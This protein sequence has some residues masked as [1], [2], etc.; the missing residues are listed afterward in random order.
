MFSLLPAAHFRASPNLLLHFG[1]PYFMNQPTSI[2]PEDLKLYTLK[3]ASG[4]SVTFL[5]LGAGIFDLYIP[6][7]NGELVNAVVGPK[8]KEDY[9]LPE[10]LSENRCFGSS[11]G[12]YAGRISH[13]KFSVNNE[14]YNLYEK[15]GVHLHG[16]R[17]GLQHK[18]WNLESVDRERNSISFSCFSPAGDEGYPGNLK[19]QVTYT[20]SIKNT[21]EVE[22]IA[23]TDKPTPV[24][25]TNHT[26]F[27]L[28]RNERVCDHRLF[29]NA[30]SILEVDEKLRP[31]GGFIRL[32][33]HT[34]NFSLPK[35]IN[36]QEVDDTFVLEKTGK[37]SAELFADSTGIKMQVETNQ[38][39]VVIYIPEEL[40]EKWEY[41]T[42]ISDFPSV[43]IETQNFPDAPN[44][45]H[46]P[47]AI[48]Y[49]GEEYRNFS[50][51]KFSIENKKD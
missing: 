13:G 49:P 45:Q 17:R 46:F 47:S 16:G 15:E 26:Y 7:K 11:V 2:S 44:H 41:K 3:N 28:S 19:V 21:L 37:I 42:G 30:A 38:P 10:Y 50:S 22:Y 8:N 23:F 33:D 40:P 25:I 43:C 14:S 34:K 12:R 9:L 35:K 31:T 1:A 4:I 24:N 18:L 6:D 48:L 32:Q 36:R 29:I 39:A 5:N 51:F 27:N 20:L